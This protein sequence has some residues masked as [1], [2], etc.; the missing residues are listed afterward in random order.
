MRQGPGLRHSLRGDVCRLRGQQGGAL[1]ARGSL[2]V[3]SSRLAFLLVELAK[4]LAASLADGLDP[5]AHGAAID[6]EELL[7]RQ[8]HARKNL[9]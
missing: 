9:T 3:G 1:C 2:L 6:V 5:L 7:L 4:L 8:H